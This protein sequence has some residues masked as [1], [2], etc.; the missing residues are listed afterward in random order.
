MYKTPSEA[1]ATAKSLKVKLIN[2][3][4]V[5]VVVC[6][7]S[8]DILAV[9]EIVA[10]TNIKIGGQ[11]MHHLDEGAFTGEISADMLKDAGCD[12]VVV[13]H[14]E[15]RHVFGE[16]DDEINKKVIKALAKGLVPIFCVGEKL[17]ER[18]AG[19][20]EEV[21][22]RQLKA[23]LAGVELNSAEKLVIAYEPVWAIGT[24]VTASPEQ[25]EEVH[26]FIRN[27]LVEIYGNDLAEQIRIQYGGS[28]KPANA[29]ELLGQPNIDGALVGGASLDPDSF[30]AIIKSAQSAK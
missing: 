9:R 29:D 17:E 4:N 6:P 5:D 18:N 14:S 2:V 20:T 16:T 15:R 7:T 27:L 21:V 28:V 13:G 24:G 23:G 12:Y 22:S 30:T 3:E 19:K 25:A 1:A 26:Q 8:I 11:N 10:G